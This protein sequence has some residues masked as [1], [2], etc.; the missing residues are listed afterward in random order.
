MGMDDEPADDMDMGGEDEPADD[1]G[2][3]Y[4]MNERRW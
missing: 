4:G 2:H 3:G 1:I